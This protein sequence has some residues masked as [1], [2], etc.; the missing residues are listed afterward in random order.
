MSTDAPKEKDLG[1][2]EDLSIAVIAARYNSLQINSLLDSVVTE[3]KDRGVAKIAIDRVPGSAE[4]PYAAA[5]I[6]K[7]ILPNAIIVLGVVIAGDTNHHN[8]I[9]HSTAD[10]LNQVS[11]DK[12]LPIINGII[13]TNSIKE[14]E[15]R[16][17]LKINR[18]KEFA[19]AAIEMAQLTHIWNQKEK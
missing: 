18:G 14:A 16:C 19:Q 12:N 4:L 17:G 9:A 6:Q 13:V 11:I 3:L 10:A 8:V 15:E 7:T 2:L 5:L 1:Q